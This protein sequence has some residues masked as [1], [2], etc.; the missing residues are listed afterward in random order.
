MIPNKAHQRHVGAIV[1]CNILTVLYC[2]ANRTVDQ[3]SFEAYDSAMDFESFD[4][5]DEEA[6]PR[7]RPR[8]VYENQRSS[9]PVRE[10]PPS[11]AAPLMEEEDE[12]GEGVV[13]EDEEDSVP[14]AKRRNMP[15]DSDGDAE[16]GPDYF[17]LSRED[18]GKQKY[19]C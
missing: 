17:G 9:T 19:V 12:R 10:A 11:P 18:M 2:T 4:E 15:A 5:E 13:K 3:F 6:F 8:S 14:D 1:T 7:K 16:E